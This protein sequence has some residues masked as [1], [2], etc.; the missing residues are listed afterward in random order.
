MKTNRRELVKMAALAFAGAPVAAV[1]ARGTLDVAALRA[2]LVQRRARIKTLR[3][4][5]TLV[6]DANDALN[7]PNE[8]LFDGS[9]YHIRHLGRGGPF[10]VIVTPQESVTALGEPARVQRVRRAQTKHWPPAPS[11]DHFLPVPFHLPMTMIGG[12]EIAGRSCV[13]LA[14]GEFRYWIDADAGA[15]L[16]RETYTKSG[17]VRLRETFSGFRDT[18]AAV[19]FPGFINIDIFDRAGAFIRRSLIVIDEVESNRE[20]DPSLFDIAR[21]RTQ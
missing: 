4:R 2:D 12:E 21:Y 17:V 20:F 18:D 10:F 19:A 9:G 6:G 7:G 13:G 11:I 8:V 16:R 1:A 15:V 14:Q 3:V 5:Y